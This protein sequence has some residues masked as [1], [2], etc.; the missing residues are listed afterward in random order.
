MQNQAQRPRLNVVVR[1]DQPLL[2][3][4]QLKEMTKRGV[5]FLLK[6]VATTAIF[7]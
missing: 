5:I 7:R 2:P 6:S 3:G 4:D 1:P